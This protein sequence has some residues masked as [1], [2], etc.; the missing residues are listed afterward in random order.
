MKITKITKILPLALALSICGC[1]FAEE[2]TPETLS[3]SATVN[4]TIDLQDYIRITTTTPNLTSTT[5]FGNDYKYININEDM[6]GSFHVISNA[7]TRTMELTAE[8]I[9]GESPLSNV[10]FDGNAGA[11]RLVFTHVSE[12]PA[13]SA[14]KD[15]ADGATDPNNNPNAIGFNVVLGQTY[16]DG[17]GSISGAWD[18]T[19]KKITYTMNNGV[20]D[21]TVKVGGK[22]IDNT[23]NTQDQSGNYKAVLT[24]TDVGPVTTGGGTGS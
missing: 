1:A 14:V 6:T 21:I 3:K 16:K 7:K 10:T 23:F 12:I 17:P 8:K 11:A 22:N 9:N 13:G 19:N 20:S 15:I 5:K 4:Y 2:E 24:L 18:N